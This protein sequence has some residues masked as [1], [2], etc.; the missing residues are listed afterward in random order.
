MKFLID[1]MCKEWKIFSI[2]DLVYNHAANDFALLREHPEA[3]Y[4][5]I[6]SPHLKPA[7]LLDLI[8]S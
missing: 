1:K 2:T 5:L 7:V 3:A 4:N 6:N 8:Y